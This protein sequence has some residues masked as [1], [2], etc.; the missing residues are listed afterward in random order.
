MIEAHEHV[1][2]QQQNVWETIHSK[3]KNAVLYSFFNLHHPCYTF[4]GEKTQLL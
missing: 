4:W 2:L 1:M 3:H